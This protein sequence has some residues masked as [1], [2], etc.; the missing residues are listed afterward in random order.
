MRSRAAFLTGA[1][2]LGLA[3][4]VA[5]A[6]GPPGGGGT[7]PFAR[8]REQHKMTFQLQTMVTR[9]LTECER[10]KN[11][12]LKPAQAKQLLSVLNPWKTKPKMTQEEARATIQQ[13]QKIFE[14]KQL[15][16]I[17]KAIQEWQ[18]RM[19]GGGGP[20]GG[21]GGA[22]GGGAPGV[23]A[24]RPGGAPGAGGPGGGRPPFDPAKAKNFNPFNP[25]KDSPMYDRSKARNDKLFAFLA[26]RASGKGGTLDLPQFGRPG[27]GGPGGAPG[28]PGAAGA[29]PKPGGAAPTK[30]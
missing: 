30:K 11:T 4:S 24:P 6:Q 16:A 14:A 19:S 22:P 10:S 13:V 3:G 20:P 1:A 5:L 9:G 7:S 21:G 23:G 15:T 29:G 8:F 26:T 2:V 18:R 17:D 12:E 28:A 25:A 27:G